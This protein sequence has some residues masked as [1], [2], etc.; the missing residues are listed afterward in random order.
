MAD[1]L[2][3]DDAKTNF[4]SEL[5]VKLFSSLISCSRIQ[6]VLLGNPYMLSVAALPKII[7]LN[8]EKKT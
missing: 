2:H 4:H 1:Y 7:F 5:D 3:Q 6:N 8:Q